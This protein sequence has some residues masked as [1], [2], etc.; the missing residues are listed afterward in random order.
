MAVGLDRALAIDRI[1]ESVDDAAEQA[2][3]DRNF[4]DGARALD[5][6]AFADVTVSTEEHDT[7]IVGFEVQAMPRTPPGNST[8]SPAWTLSRP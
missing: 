6:V 7:D 1:A 5:G 4:D 2:L 8:I 3:A